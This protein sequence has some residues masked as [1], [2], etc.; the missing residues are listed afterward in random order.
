MQAI[1]GLAKIIRPLKAGLMR[2]ERWMQVRAKYKCGPD[3]VMWRNLWAVLFKTSLGLVRSNYNTRT[4]LFCYIT[5]DNQHMVYFKSTNISHD[6]T[7]IKGC[8]VTIVALQKR[9]YVSLVPSG[10]HS[11]CADTMVSA[12][13]WS[14]AQP[15]FIIRKYVNIPEGI[16]KK[17]KLG[18]M[19]LM[20][21]MSITNI[22]KNL[23][24]NWDQIQ[25]L[26]P[27]LPLFRLH[28]ARIHRPKELPLQY[29]RVGKWVKWATVVRTL[30]TVGWY[31][32]HRD[33]WLPLTLKFI[34]TWL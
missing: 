8:H 7:Y 34:M 10:H 15:A 31:F 21:Q 6:A 25:H 13:G 29:P 12:T 11:V 14:L 20:N 28:I 18:K 4:W 27:F 5:T 23:Y 32:P 26:K 2:D 9:G 16:K 22:Y 17:K 19:L 30:V 24:G 1:I 3:D 33:I